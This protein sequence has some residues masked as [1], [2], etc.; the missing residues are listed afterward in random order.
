MSNG[1][2]PSTGSRGLRANA[3]LVAIL[4]V[5]FIGRVGV[6]LATRHLTMRDDSADYVRLGLVLSHGHGFGESVLAAG[7]GPTAFRAPVYPMFLGTVFRLTSDSLTAARLLQAVTGTVTVALIGVL[8]WQLFDRRHAIVAAGLAAVYPPLILVGDAVQTES[9][10]LPLELLVLVLALE[11]RRR[12]QGGLLLPVV[13]GGLIGLCIL[14]R[15]ANIAMVVPVVLLVTWRG[16]RA[17]VAPSLVVVAMVVTLLPWQIRNQATFHRFVPVS[18][19]DA[20]IIAGV[21]NDQAAHDPV[22]RAVWRPPTII[23]GQAEL[24]ADPTLDEVELA[25]AL[26]TKGTDYAKHHVGYIP[27]VLA[28]NLL[29]LLDLGGLARADLGHLSEGYGRGWSRL[30]TYSYFVVALLAVAG[31]FS[32]RAR[33]APLAVW[34]TPVLFVLVT[35]PTLGTSRYRAPI[36]PFLVLLAAIPILALLDRGRAGDESATSG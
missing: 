29:H 5:A 27:V 11:H 13:G 7:G 18:T 24:F 28:V 16:R 10:S 30:W 22:N 35:I 2:P 33:Q 20:F 8:A 6:V 31:A 12:H 15:P 32:K 26:R 9:I 3:D 34:L 21:Y 4:A 25:D 17:F 19:A 36:E 14:T 1:A 23:P